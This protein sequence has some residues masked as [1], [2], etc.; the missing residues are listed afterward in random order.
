M[1]LNDA[2][3]IA[4]L[5]RDAD[6]RGIRRRLKFNNEVKTRHHLATYIKKST[7]VCNEDDLI[8]KLS[9]NATLPEHITYEDMQE[10]SH[11]VYPE[12]RDVVPAPVATTE[13]R[14]SSWLRVPSA[15]VTPNRSRNA[16]PMS[17]LSRRS[18]FSSFDMGQMD[19]PSSDIMGSAQESQ[20]DLAEDED[21]FEEFTDDRLGAIC[22]A[23]RAGPGL[24]AV[25]DGIL[26]A[27]PGAGFPAANTHGYLS[28]TP[29]SMKAQTLQHH[30]GMYHASQAEALKVQWPLRQANFEAGQSHRREAERYLG[31]SLGAC[32]CIGQS[33]EAGPG[34]SSLTRMAEESI[35]EAR[36]SL[37]TML[38]TRNGEFLSTISSLFAVLEAHGQVDFAKSRLRDAL[39]VATGILGEAHAVI[40]SIG[41]MLA[42]AGRTSDLSPECRSDRLNMIRAGIEEYFG[43]ESRSAL[44]AS[45]HVGWA[46]AH[47]KRY[48]QAVEVLGLL[49]ARCETV[50]G[51]LHIHTAM[52]GL[53][54]ARVYFHKGHP[55]A[56]EHLVTDMIG[57]LERVFD[58]RHPYR[59]EVRHRQAMF[60][61]KL[62]KRQ[63]AEAVLREV[64][65]ERYAVLGP[66]NPRSTSSF[67][68]LQNLLME[69]G[70][71]EEANGLWQEMS[72]Q[73]L[74]LDTHWAF[75]G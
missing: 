17:S 70:R 69:D 24:G 73:S 18:S 27:V 75:V 25:V 11:V 65:R 62:G 5:L 12:A 68:T 35:L 10:P 55:D 54:L 3:H 21:V 33:Y 4:W 59:L 71:F 26:T 48:D 30:Q 44:T 37:H 34:P 63:D 60:L 58:K 13:G 29:T 6:R 39:E 8:A 20:E 57:R 38:S 16:T 72:S 42:V 51:P 14:V 66:A 9:P 74:N 52:A 2:A 49:R 22:A 45:Y 31:A 36:Q 23:E 47:E 50:F 56:A 7:K 46:L 43:A 64:V 19:L 41:Y 28:F 15:E 53:T 67:K 61:T 1:N 32:M 40:G